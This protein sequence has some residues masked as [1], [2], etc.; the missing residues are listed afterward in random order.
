MTDVHSK[1]VRVL[2]AILLPGHFLFALAIALMK[3]GHATVTPLFMIFY[4]AAAFLQVNLLSPAIIL[5]EIECVL[6][7][8][9]VVKEIM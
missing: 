9:T 3:S 1:T 7:R 8:Q 2:L 5:V 4:L 6:N